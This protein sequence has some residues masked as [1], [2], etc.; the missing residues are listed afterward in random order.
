MSF[1]QRSM[2]FLHSKLRINEPPRAS[3]SVDQDQGSDGND[4]Q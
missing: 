4:D 2:G 3:A 1:L